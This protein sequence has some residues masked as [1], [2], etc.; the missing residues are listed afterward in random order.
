MG[1][2]VIVATPTAPPM[3]AIHLPAVHSSAVGLAAQANPLT[4]WGQV[5]TQALQNTKVLA[6]G[7]IADPFPILGQIVKNEVASAST[8]GGSLRAFLTAAGGQL[9]QTPAMVKQAFGQ[10]AAG[11]ITDGLI[12]LFQ[13][14]LFP[15]VVPILNTSLLT[16][17]QAAVAKPV[18]NVVNVINTAITSP[19]GAGWLLTAGFPAI[20]LATDMVTA[21]GDSIQGV[22]SAVKSGNLGAVLGA[23]FA[24]PA[25]ITGALLN[26]Y[27]GDGG[28]LLG[29]NGIVQG[30]R[31]ALH[32]IAQAITPTAPPASV[33]ATNAAQPRTAATLSTSADPVSA[34]EKSAPAATTSGKLAAAAPAS[35][36]PTAER[37]VSAA[38]PAA[39]ADSGLAATTSG[40]P[41]AVAAAAPV[42]AAPT[43]KPAV[44]S[45]TPVPTDSAPAGNPT[46]ATDESV[47]ANA[48]PAKTDL[49]GSGSNK[50]AVS[51]SAA[52]DGS[53]AQ[54]GVVAKDAGDGA[55][56]P[57]HKTAG[58]PKKDRLSVK[59]GDNA[60]SGGN[61]GRSH[62]SARGGGE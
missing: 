60:G 50:K 1:A 12:T 29:P 40:T 30:L 33:A 36:A 17:I 23:I 31:N 16:D 15:I 37:P 6:T 14:A 7:V 32:I 19:S 47:G 41:A 56:A 44:P 48:S 18:Q 46:A 25:T 24:I 62:G 4:D 26:G 34:A 9:A 57:T 52:S 38:K 3:P 58:K 45:A 59:N 55:A 39:S 10:I 42:S 5:L 51:G 11:Q 21:T 2:S 43:A 13:A 53:A 49:R 22:L 27:A 28:G 61:G 20:Q 35:V 8:L 54:T